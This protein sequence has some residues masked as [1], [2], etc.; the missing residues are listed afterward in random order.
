MEGS[1]QARSLPMR[2]DS[3]ESRRQTNK[4]GSKDKKQMQKCNSSWCSATAPP[5]YITV[6]KDP[7]PRR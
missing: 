6:R 4:M 3:E 5:V 1:R 2:T 7:T